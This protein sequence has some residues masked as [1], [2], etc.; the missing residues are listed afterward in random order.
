VQRVVELPFGLEVG[1]VAG[2]VDDHQF[3]VPEAG[4][5]LGV[6]AGPDGWRVTILLATLA[7]I[8]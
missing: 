2:A 3:G 1:Q 8:G 6:D 5:D 7:A 4:D